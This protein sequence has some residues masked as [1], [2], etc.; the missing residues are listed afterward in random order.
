[1]VVSKP[2]LKFDPRSVNKLPT[3]RVS[4]L[5]SVRF[6]SDGAPAKNPFVKR[7]GGMG[8]G[9]RGGGNRR[10][11]RGGGHPID[12]MMP[13]PPPPPDI[14]GYHPLVYMHPHDFVGVGHEFDRQHQDML[15]AQNDALLFQGEYSDMARSRY[16]AELLTGELDAY[17]EMELGL[18]DQFGVPVYDDLVGD[19]LGLIGVDHQ[20]VLLYERQGGLSKYGFRLCILILLQ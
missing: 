14:N 20:D 1:M 17:R 13:P 12:R 3:L 19:E 11:G 16:N 18:T 2:T 9:G 7:G 4:P 15:L 8:G 5:M 10:G 6:R